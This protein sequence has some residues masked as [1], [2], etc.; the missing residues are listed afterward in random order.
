MKVCI[1]SGVIS[2]DKNNSDVRKKYLTERIRYFGTKSTNFTILSPLVSNVEYLNYDNLEYNHYHCIQKKGL[3]LLSSMVFSIP[4]LIEVDCDIL[5][6]LNYQSFFIAKFVNFFRK[7]KYTIIFEAMG[8]AYAESTIDATSSLKVKLL[9]PAINRLERFAFQKSDGVIVYT[10]ILKQYATD[11]FNIDK[12]KIYV[13]PHGVNLE[14]ENVTNLVYDD[15]Q[16][17]C[18]ACKSIAMYVGSLSDLHGTPYLMQIALDLSVKRPDVCILILGTGPSKTLFDKFIEENKLTNVILMGYLPSEKIPFYMNKADV[19]LIPHSH[20]LQTE[21][22]PPTKLF[23]YLKAGKPIVSFDFKAIAEIVGDKAVLI[24][25]DNPSE[26]V[27]GIIDVLDNKEHYLKL[28]EKA[29][30]IVNQYSWEASAEKQLHAYYELC[31][32]YRT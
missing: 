12:E 25:P 13:V 16:M 30:S 17:I 2:L 18:P 27:E 21:L 9:R 14:I 8:L 19:L 28:A 6:C 4:K 3:K 24:E 23:E 22:D 31:A 11:H 10:E 29:R 1:Y 5:H 32:R 20:C 26:F 7:Q 15:L